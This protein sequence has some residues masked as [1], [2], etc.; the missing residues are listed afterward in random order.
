[1]EVGFSCSKTVLFF[2]QARAEEEGFGGALHQELR[3]ALQL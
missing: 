1:M 2:A 3:E